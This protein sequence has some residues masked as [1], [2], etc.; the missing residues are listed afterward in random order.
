MSTA[1]ED[2]G[3]LPL[4]HGDGDEV[5][6]GTVDD[7]GG[8]PWQPQYEHGN[9]VMTKVSRR[10]LPLIFSYVLLASLTKTNVSY[11]ASGIIA[12]VHITDSQYGAASSFF[13]FVYTLSTIPTVLCVKRVGASR[14]LAIMIFGFGLVTATT[15]FVSDLAGFFLS[16]GCLALAEAGVLQTIYYVL[17]LFYPPSEYAY[18]AAISVGL[19]QVRAPVRQHTAYSKRRACRR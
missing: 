9:L 16:R 5:E 11:A 19:G 18:N 4:L 1:D 3:R 14:G 6:A 17:S 2:D 15:A 12:S 13:V 10:M 7:D 8:A